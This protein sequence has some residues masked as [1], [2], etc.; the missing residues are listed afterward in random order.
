MAIGFLIGSSALVPS[1]LSERFTSSLSG[2]VE[3]S[4]F[5]DNCDAFSNMAVTTMS[6]M[7]SHYSGTSKSVSFD[8]GSARNAGFSEDEIT[9][10]SKLAEYSDAIARLNKDDEVPSKS[11]EVSWFFN[12][13]SAAL[14]EA[15]QSDSTEVMTACED[16]FWSQAACT[17]GNVDYPK[18]DRS[19]NPPHEVDHSDP[20]QALLD[21]QFVR[22]YYPFA[23][24]QTT[25]YRKNRTYQSNLCGNNTF[26]QHAWIHDSDTYRMQRYNGWTPPGEPNPEVHLAN[27][28]PYWTWPAYVLWWHNRD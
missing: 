25:E 28:W 18:P 7:N 13:A 10:A 8:A 23:Q 17:C 16:T 27:F 21:L 22:V 3:P 14:N 15:S 2:E 26:R 1:G 20:N 5:M 9:L 11:A 24:W 4:G 12:C 19:D 6:K